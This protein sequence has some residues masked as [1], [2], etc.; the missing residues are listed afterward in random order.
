VLAALRRLPDYL[1]L[2]G[3]LMVDS[4]VSRID[5]ALV[6]L[7]AAY[8]V[9]PIDFIPDVI[10]FL[11][12]VDDL[13]LLALSLQRLVRRTSRRVLLDHW[14][15]DPEVLSEFSLSRMLGAAAFFLPARTRRRLE[16]LA[17]R[18]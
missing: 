5:R 8:I 9:T 6:V 2:L 3:G 15:G 1:R 17:D 16:R 12:E 7:A 14:P 11:G 4:R 10:P 13:F 18:G